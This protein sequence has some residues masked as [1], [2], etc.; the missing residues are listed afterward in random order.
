MYSTVSIRESYCCNFVFKVEAFGLEEITELKNPYAPH[1]HPNVIKTPRGQDSLISDIRS[2][3]M[4]LD[5]VL[6]KLVW[7]E[8]IP[9]REAE[10]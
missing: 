5:F 3:S 1:I 10:L 7:G 8:N 4:Y 9:E 2:C 6:K